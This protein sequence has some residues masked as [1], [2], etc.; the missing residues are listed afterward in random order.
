MLLSAVLYYI[1]DVWFGENDS[2]IETARQMVLAARRTEALQARAKMVSQCLSAKGDIIDQLVAGRLRLRK[3]IA[4][5]QEANELVENVDRDLIPPYQTPTDPEG[6]GR[7]VLL[8][9]RNAVAS[10]PPEKAQRLLSDL[11]RE[12]RTL[13]HGANPS[14]E[15][16][17]SP[18]D[19][20]TP[21]RTE[22][23]SAG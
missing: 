20:E 7:H 18:M 2:V 4:Q 19:T 16:G 22:M 3:A 10:L 6:V 23:H 21:G 12:Y 15:A 8:W 5:F 14:K 9:A 11:E 17:V 1:A 13:F